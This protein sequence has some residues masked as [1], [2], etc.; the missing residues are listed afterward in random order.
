MVPCVQR[1]IQCSARRSRRWN[2]ALTL[3][4]GHIGAAQKSRILV[5]RCVVLQVAG[6]GQG[7][8]ALT[9]QLSFSMH[10]AVWGR[11]PD[12][13]VTSAPRKTPT[14]LSSG[15]LYSRSLA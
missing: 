7:A 1:E 2:G 5:Q 4:K 6:R 14:F 10:K 11:L 12:V 9:A 8:C 15:V 13:K 3:G